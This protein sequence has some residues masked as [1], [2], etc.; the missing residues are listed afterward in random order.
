[1]YLLGPRN[2]HGYQ[3]CCLAVGHLQLVSP[4][5]WCSCNQ[6]RLAPAAAQLS[7][8]TR[9]FFRQGTSQR[10][11]CWSWTTQATYLSKPVFSGS[12]WKISCWCKHLIEKGSSLVAGHEQLTTRLHLHEAASASEIDHPLIPVACC[13]T[14]TQG[15]PDES[16]YWGGIA[17]P[18]IAFHFCVGRRTRTSKRRISPNLVARW[19]SFQ[20]VG[21]SLF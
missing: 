9:S 4:Q 20:I 19:R 8:G 15:V 18:N 10:P 14:P 12:A 7:S 1:L 6:S 21:P 16:S 11:S 3:T 2:Q 5:G 13:P 17:N